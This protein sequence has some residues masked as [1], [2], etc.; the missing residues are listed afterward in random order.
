MI[1]APAR[2]GLAT[3]ND[4]Y[5]LRN[6]IWCGP[7]DVPMYPNPAWGQRT[8]K[9][10]LGCRRIALPADA[11]ESVTWTAAERRATLDAIAPPCRQS[12]LELL[13]VKVIVV[14]DAPDD[15]AFVW[16]T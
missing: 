11:I 12:V 8:Y 7:C 13:L 14:S 1:P 3:T 5:L 16:R 15:L 4:P 9:C 10:G 2:V 6:L